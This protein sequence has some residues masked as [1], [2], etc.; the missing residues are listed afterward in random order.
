ML[1]CPLDEHS[2]SVLHFQDHE[3]RW[4]AVFCFVFFPSLTYKSVILPSSYC[5]F[6]VIF[7]ASVHKRSTKKTAS[8]VLLFN[9]GDTEKTPQLSRKCAVLHVHTQKKPPPQLEGKRIFYRCIAT[10]LGQIPN[11]HSFHLDRTCVQSFALQASCLTIN[12]A[13]V[14]NRSQTLILIMRACYV[15]RWTSFQLQK[16]ISRRL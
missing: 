5:S 9:T 7:R 14:C 10:S 13:V 3:V 4:R 15:V 11:L 1:S 2:R 8:T 16:F 12:K 6:G